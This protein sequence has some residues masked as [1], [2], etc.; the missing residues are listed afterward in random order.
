MAARGRTT[1][2]IGR[3]LAAAGLAFV[4]AMTLEPKPELVPFAER[5]PFWCLVCG[6]MGVI[7]VVLNVVLFA[8]L[9]AGLRLAG[10]A[11]RRV[12][13]VG[14]AVTLAV[15]LLQLTLVT[16]RDASVSDLVTNTS[17]ALLGAL[18]A[19]LV[20]ALLRPGAALRRGL[21][22]GWTALWACALVV[23]AAAHGRSLPRTDYW[24]Q[25]GADL[26]GFDTF[27]GRVLSAEV[28]GRALPGGERLRESGVIRRLLL[29]ES[30]TLATRIVAAGPTTRTAPV[31]SVFDEN[32]DEIL[33][34]GQDG[35]DLVFRLRA[36]AAAMKVRT[37]AVRL[38]DALAGRAGDTL[39]ID[40]RYESGRLRLA[41]AP[42][43]GPDGGPAASHEVALAPTLGWALFLPYDYAF[44]PEVHLLT[45]LWVAGL[46]A[47][48][49]YWSAVGRRRQE[50]GIAAG[51]AAL[52]L[53]G[54]SAA[55]GAPWPHPWHWLAAAAGF[56]VGAA[57]AFGRA[58]RD[59][60]HGRA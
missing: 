21:T 53:V 32:Q 45:A 48:L 5:T 6:S 7:D 8:P 39:R 18:L 44:G 14:A 59:R 17:G 38:D 50:V 27:P 56:G 35:D 36:R 19:D 34:L 33:L 43:G 51:A 11:H 55:A 16:G 4:A 37:P 20:P 1:R 30:A 31:V 54:V 46:L 15:E 23:A 22:V 25:W 40:A 28:D 58:A 13:L 2:N 10:L 9:G 47:P 49:G 57:A 52:A 42:D 60:T 3:G 26:A 41:L 29:G 12:V 24:G